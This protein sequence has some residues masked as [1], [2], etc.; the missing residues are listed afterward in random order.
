MASII[1]TLMVPESVSDP[2]KQSCTAAIEKLAKVFSYKCCEVEDGILSKGGD[3]AF[4]LTYGNM[5]ECPEDTTVSDCITVTDIGG[6]RLKL[7]DWC[8]PCS[9]YDIWMS[10][11]FY[12]PVDGNYYCL[13]FPIW[14][15]FAYGLQPIVCPDR[16]LCFYVYF[17]GEDFT[18]NPHTIDTFAA[19]FQVED[20]FCND[21]PCTCDFAKAEIPS[22]KEMGLS[23]DDLKLP[24]EELEAKLRKIMA[25]QD[26]KNNKA[27]V[28]GK[29]DVEL[30]REELEEKLKKIVEQ[31]EREKGTRITSK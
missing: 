25:Q 31:D 6:I 3:Y 15:I 14:L 5:G 23:V 11:C 8:P 28:T 16:P 12:Y 17:P 4:T 26:E 18:I 1:N 19:I 20:I 27:K 21:C 29:E 10:G 22:M 7:M 30:S 13:N 24:K 2:S 9:G